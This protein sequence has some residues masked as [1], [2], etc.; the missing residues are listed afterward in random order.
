MEAE[1][2][3]TLLPLSSILY[4]VVVCRAVHFP[5]AFQ[6]PQYYSFPPSHSYFSHPRCL[7]LSF[8]HP[9]SSILLFF[10]LSLL[11]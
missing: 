11:V 9:M 6:P 7:L 1:A 3:A 4:W 5:I 8:L 2:E 10:S